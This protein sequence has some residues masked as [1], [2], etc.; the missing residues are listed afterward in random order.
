MI[1]IGQTFFSLHFFITRKGNE[2]FNYVS[3]SFFTVIIGVLAFVGVMCLLIVILY[4]W[5]RRQYGIV[6]GL[7]SCHNENAIAEANL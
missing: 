2:Y 6:Q 3:L 7:V 5:R 1:I 4:R